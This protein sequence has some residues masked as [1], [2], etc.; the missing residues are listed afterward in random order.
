MC[1]S[2]NL[3]SQSAQ[4]IDSR[5]Q[6]SPEPPCSGEVLPSLEDSPEPPCSGERTGTASYHSGPAGNPGGTNSKKKK[7]FHHFGENRFCFILKGEPGPFLARALL[8][9]ADSARAVLGSSRL[10]TSARPTLRRK[11][12]GR[13]RC[14]F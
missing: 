12:S 7:V 3:L 2:R 10:K 6:E 8:A 9:Q 4:E 5:L 11:T 13:V 1:A 14:R